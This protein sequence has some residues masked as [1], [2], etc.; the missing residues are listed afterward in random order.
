MQQ[1]LVGNVDFSLPHLSTEVSCHASYHFG[2]NLSNSAL[3]YTESHGRDEKHLDRAQH[4]FLVLMDDAKKLF[5]TLS[6][7]AYATPTLFVLSARSPT[8]V[9]VSS[10]IIHYQCCQPA[11]MVIWC[12]KNQ[13]II[14]THSSTR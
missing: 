12:L 6:R 10:M 7:V 8:C 9:G 3:Y 4:I 1:C 11:V 2:N 5:L 14:V 13:S